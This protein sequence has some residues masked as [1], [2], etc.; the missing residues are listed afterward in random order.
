MDAHLYPHFTT[1]EHGNIIAYSDGHAVTIVHAHSDEHAHGD[2]DSDH[3][4][5]ATRD[6]TEQRGQLRDVAESDA[7]GTALA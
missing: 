2:A 5:R 4:G 7:P 6:A 3:P 1:D